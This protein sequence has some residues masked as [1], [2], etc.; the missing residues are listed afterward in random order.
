M[1]FP[2]IWNNEKK[3]AI[4]Q[5]RLSLA[6]GMVE[7]VNPFV[8]QQIQDANGKLVHIT[9]DTQTQMEVVDRLAGVSINGV[10]LEREVEVKEWR[11]RQ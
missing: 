11:A 5:R 3:A 1:A 6:K 7:E 9:G 10:K 2:L 4:D 8:I